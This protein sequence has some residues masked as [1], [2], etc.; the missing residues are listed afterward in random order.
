LRTLVANRFADGAVVGQRI[1][2]L[3]S[4]IVAVELADCL[5]RAGKT[6]HLI[7][8]DNRLAGEVGKK[9]RGE[10]SRRLDAVGVIV[11]TGVEMGQVT[12]EGVHITVA[13]KPQLV[14]ADTVLVPDA[15]VADTAL[16]DSL[17]GVAPVVKAIGDCTGFG[18]IRKAVKDATEA[19]YAL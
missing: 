12:A 19:V 8:S 6:V 14:R 13:G 2:V 11:N 7:S 4:G 10:E 9:R 3:G 16:A 18:L 15:Y 17:A 5:A 1:A